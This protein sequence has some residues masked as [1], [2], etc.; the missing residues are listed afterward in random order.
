M[1]SVLV[2][3][4]ADEDMDSNAQRSACGDKHMLIPFQN[5]DL[6]AALTDSQGSE[7]NQEVICTVPDLISILGQD[8]EAVG[9]Q[10]LRYGLCVNVIALPAHSLWKTE[11]GLPIGGPKAFGWDMPFVGV[12]EYTEPRSVIEEFGH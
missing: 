2:A 11:K 3:P 8:G 6:Y 1:G 12:G 7:S 5:D 10:D 9:S 4:L